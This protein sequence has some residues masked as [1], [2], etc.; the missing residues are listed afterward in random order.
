MQSYSLPSYSYDDLTLGASGTPYTAPADGW[1]TFIWY[2]E[3]TNNV[4]LTSRKADGTLLLVANQSYTNAGNHAMFI[5]VI[6]N[7]IFIINY[8]NMSFRP[9]LG[10]FLRFIYAH[11]SQ[12][13]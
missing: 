9:D 2:G 8:D 13:S 5:P 3:I 1:V 6:K 12:Q 11:G 4:Y 7:Q 10:N